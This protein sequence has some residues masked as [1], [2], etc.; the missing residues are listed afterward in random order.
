MDL[1][2]LQER[3]IQ[4]VGYEEKSMATVSNFCSYGGFAELK[5]FLSCADQEFQEDTKESS[6]SRCLHDILEEAQSD[7]PVSFYSHLDSSEGS[8]DEVRHPFYHSVIINYNGE[9]SLLF[10]FCRTS[11]LV[12]VHYQKNSYQKCDLNSHYL[13]T[14]KLVLQFVE[15]KLYQN[16]WKPTLPK[17]SEIL[18]CTHK[19]D[20]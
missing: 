1:A 10:S 13:N 12:S 17:T 2:F 3:T 14:H 15:K 18:S 5:D 7:S 4:P 20:L 6:D 9:Q 11:A 16:I 19:H 8:D